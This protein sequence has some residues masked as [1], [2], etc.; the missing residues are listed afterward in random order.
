MKLAHDLGADAENVVSEMYS[1]PRV[2]SAA[3][4]LKSLGIVP[5]FAMDL[6]ASFAAKRMSGRS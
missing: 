3:G 1:P 2:T 6:L 5:G 4:K